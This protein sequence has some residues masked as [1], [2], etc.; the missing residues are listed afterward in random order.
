MKIKKKPRKPQ[1]I[2]RTN[3]NDFGILCQML[4]EDAQYPDEIEVCGACLSKTEAKKL[5]KWL[6]NA[7]Q[8]LELK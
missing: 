1:I 5:F 3:P 7:I 4:F 6:D 2:N 8:Y